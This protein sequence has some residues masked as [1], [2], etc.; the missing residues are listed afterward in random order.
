MNICCER[1]AVPVT[2]R[3]QQSFNQIGISMV[4]LEAPDLADEISTQSWLEKI[5]TLDGACVLA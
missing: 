4:F 5:L 3:P 2:R 1:E